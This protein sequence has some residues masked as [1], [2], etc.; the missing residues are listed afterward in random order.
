MAVRIR[1][2]VMWGPIQVPLSS[3][4]SVRLSPLQ[5]S[6]DLP[7]VEVVNNAKVDKLRQQ[8]LIDVEQVADEQAEGA[9]TDEAPDAEQRSRGRK[10]AAPSA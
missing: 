10:R 8:G 4:P 5:L 7:D 1:S 3:G 9:D 2:L 6:D